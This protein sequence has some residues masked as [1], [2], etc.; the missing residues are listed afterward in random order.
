MPDTSGPADTTMMGVMHDALRRDFARTRSVL[1][2]DATAPQQQRTAVAAHVPFMLEF[3]HAHH[4]SEDLHLWPMVRDRDASLGPLLDSMSRDHAA[5]AAH[6]DALTEAA[7][8]YSTDAGGRARGGLVDALDAFSAVLLP[9]LAREEAEMMPRVSECL[10]D[11]EW[12]AFERAAK[13]EMPARVL[14]E[15]LNW[16]LDG[17]DEPRRRYVLRALPAPI[18]LV[19][20]R[21]YGPGYRRRAARRWMSTSSP[22]P[23]G[24]VGGGVR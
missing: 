13:P 18:V 14:A 22:A 15:Y 19:S 4:S 5:I 11:D 10:T 3:L 9:H 12:H 1:T 23:G 7:G 24:S 6:V 21:L 17:L 20:T 16:F 2:A 8:R